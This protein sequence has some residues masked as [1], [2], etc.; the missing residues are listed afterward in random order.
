[1][2][3]KKS[4]SKVLQIT[5]K[6]DLI[7]IW[8]VRNPSSTRFT[9]RKNHFSGFIQRQLDYIFIS[10][11]VQESVQNIDV[12][13]SFCSDHSSLL[14][15][16]KKLPPSNLGKNFWKLN[17]S[18]IHDELYVL[19]MK[20]HIE[21]NINSFDSDFNDQ[22]KWEFLKYKIRKFTI[23]FS[24]NKTKSMREKKLNLEKKLKL[25]EGKTITR[26][27]MN[28]TF[29]RKIVMLFTMK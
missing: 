13:P 15:S 16:Y 4:I 10:I 18:L 17:C 27:K 21:N 25:V 26:L 28:T 2:L 9:F 19:K 29:A 22:M 24:K 8:R 14:L 6:H 5:E 20:K 11:S 23:S 7:D 12:L 1:M 3:K